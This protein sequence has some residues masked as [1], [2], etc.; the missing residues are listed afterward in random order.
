MNHP[1]FPL[2][3]HNFSEYYLHIT[4]K[5]PKNLNFWLLTI[6]ILFGIVSLV[7]AFIFRKSTL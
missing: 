5:K 7:L 1:K 2:C 3:Y 6:N 4:S